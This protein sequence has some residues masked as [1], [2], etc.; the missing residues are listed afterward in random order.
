M[1]WRGKP[2]RTHETIVSLISSTTTNSGLSVQAV[3]DLNKYP[4]GIEVTKQEMM[5]VPIVRHK[6]HGEWNYTIHPK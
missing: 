2:L 1:N 3:H 5:D 6:F 4:K